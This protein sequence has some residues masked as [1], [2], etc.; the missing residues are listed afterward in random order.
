MLC[1]TS[2][3]ALL[4]ACG[5]GGPAGDAGTSN[6]AAESATASGRDAAP[7]QAAGATAVA[8][9]RNLAHQ[10][11]VT[12]SSTQQA[13]LPASAAVDGNK[14]SRWSSAFSD[15]Q[16]IKVDLGGMNNINRVVLNW[17]A[18]YGK[19]F[20]IR[21][22]SDGGI[23]KTVYETSSGGGGT[24]DIGFAITGARYVQ[25]LGLRRGTPWGYSL[26][27][28]QV[29]GDGAGPADPP[30]GNPN[31][32]PGNPPPATPGGNALPTD[33]IFSP[34]SF[35]YAPIPH[36]APLHANSAGFVSDFLRQMRAY[37]GNV[38]INT[39]AYASPVFNAPANTATRQVQYWD[40]QNK[41]YADSGLASQWAAVPIPG[42]AAKSDGTDGEMT[43]YQPSSNTLWEFWQARTVNGQ[44]QACWG[45]RM[46]NVSSSSGIWPQNY[47][48][49][50]TGLP[51]LGG[52]ITA[53]EL[54]RGEIRHAIGI[55]LVELEKSSVVSWPAN[56]SDG[57]NPNNA[58]NRI[59]EGLRLRLDPAVDVDALNLHPV[60]R[61]IA[62]AAQK[63]GFVVWDKS[64]AIALRAQ[65][66]KS[67]TALG[68]ADPYVA[69]FGGTQT[70]ALLNGFP[71]DRLQFMPKD[72][73]RP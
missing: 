73:G 17:E 9:G 31:P 52:Q 42:N 37:Y 55:S 59:P 18:A 10:R 48:T 68:Q 32:P 38:T 1:A 49:T 72:Y 14:N 67:Y 13:S 26:Y 46:Q 60:A 40:C 24:A 51:F 27:E 47:G 62:K 21:V 41:G 64:G 61:T 39:T 22:S 2:L 34:S 19:A 16:W 71:W 58:G 15:A 53:E 54:K 70:Y 35:W 69:L 12:A 43:I 5:G 33:A 50:A 57:Y 56:R 11:S 23:W 20:Q 6:T 25:M 65:N 8:G 30:P 29:F 63:Y 4:A 36:N 45:G 28:L 66:P 3:A 44:W 7:D